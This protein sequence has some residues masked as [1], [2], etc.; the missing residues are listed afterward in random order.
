MSNTSLTEASDRSVAATFT[1]IVPTSV[2]PGVPLKFR[3]DGSNA[4]QAGS[5]EPPASAAE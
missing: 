2:L 1:W 4:S 5:G 3:P